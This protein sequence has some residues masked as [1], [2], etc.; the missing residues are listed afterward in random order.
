VSRRAAPLI[1]YL[2]RECRDPRLDPTARAVLG[3]LGIDV[4]SLVEAALDAVTP[5]DRDEEA[6]RDLAR[7]RE[8]LR[9][10]QGSVVAGA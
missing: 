1:F 4:L 10:A 7:A 5:D 9:A 8:R 2:A 6:T 3:A